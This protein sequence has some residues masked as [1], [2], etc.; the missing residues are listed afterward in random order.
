MR[1]LLLLLLLP[2]APGPAQ[3]TC[4]TDPHGTTL[5]SSPEGVIRGSTS[6]IGTSIYRDDSGNRLEYDSDASGKSSL[7]LPSGKSIE[8]SHPVPVERNTPQTNDLRITPS[9]VNPA[10]PGAG[11]LGPPWELPQT[12]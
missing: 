8:W 2:A 6:S 9:G 1:M 10:T 7:Q 11:P 12:H 3:T 5:C 4:F